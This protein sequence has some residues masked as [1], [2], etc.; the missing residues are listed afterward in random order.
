MESWYTE[1]HTKNVRFSIKV[2]KHLVSKQSE[3]QRIDV[4]ESYEFGRFLTLDVLLFDQHL[5]FH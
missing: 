1:E 5:N 2:D 4:F 3:F